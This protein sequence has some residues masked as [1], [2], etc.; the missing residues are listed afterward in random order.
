MK[1][2]VKF[3]F[4]CFNQ[5]SVL[6]TNFH[7]VLGIINQLP[8]TRSICQPMFQHQDIRSPDERVALH[9]RTQPT[10]VSRLSSF[11]SLVKLYSS[12]F[13]LFIRTV[14]VTTIMHNVSLTDLNGS[15]VNV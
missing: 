12:M 6:K 7:K 4:M 5:Q 9:R 3:M 8:V 10:N 15:C 11:N 14:P 1:I 13:F 2:T